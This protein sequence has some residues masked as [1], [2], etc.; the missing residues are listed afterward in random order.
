MDL[1]QFREIA[2]LFHSVLTQWR[3][4]S[5]R[6]LDRRILVDRSQPMTLAYFV[7]WVNSGEFQNLANEARKCR[8][9]LLEHANY[10]EALSLV[11][12]CSPESLGEIRFPDLL[13]NGQDPPAT[14]FEAV[15]RYVAGVDFVI[16]LHTHRRAITYATPSTTQSYVDRINATVPEDDDGQQIELGLSIDRGLRHGQR[17]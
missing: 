8:D 6:F 12:E 17:A 2:D 15:V 11:S 4:L 14:A 5:K 16:W 9:A 10:S 1:Q 7:E 13:L 3:S